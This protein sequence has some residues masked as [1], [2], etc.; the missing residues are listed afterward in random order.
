MT[1]GCM[2]RPG[3]PRPTPSAAPRGQFAGAE[4]VAH[5]QLDAALRERDGALAREVRQ[6][7]RERTLLGDAGVEGLLAVEAGRERQRLAA[8]LAEPREHADEEVGVGDRLAD[9]ERGVPTG[10]RVQVLLA[11]RG[12]RLRVVDRQLGSGISSTQARTT[13]R[14][15]AAAPRWPIESAITR[16]ASAGSMKQSG[17]T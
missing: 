7:D 14:T 5:V 17:V 3:D 8:A 13:S 4:A 11:E 16:I 6:H 2:H 10:E 9:V 1:R 12:D 15:S